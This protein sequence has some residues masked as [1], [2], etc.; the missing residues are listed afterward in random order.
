LRSLAG[1]PL[2]LC[3]HS[4]LISAGRVRPTTS[5]S[6]PRQRDAAVAVAPVAP[7]AVAVAVTVAVAVAA[8]AA[9]AACC[10]L[11]LLLAHALLLS[12]ERRDARVST[13]AESQPE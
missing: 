13:A 4:R 10:L 1:Q 12:G 9:A 11:P 3:A 2:L 7:V 6:L 8:V 5:S